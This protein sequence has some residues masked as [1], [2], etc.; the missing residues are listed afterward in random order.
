LAAAIATAG[1][2]PYVAAGYLSPDALHDAIVRTRELTPAPLGVNLFLVSPSTADA[3]A[4]DDY[5]QLL[6]PEA[7]NFGV[8]LGPPRWD[9]DAF[10]EK[11]D[12]IIA[13][14]VHTVSTTF[15]SPHEDVID[16]LHA[17]GIQ[18]AVTVTSPEEATTA[19]NAGADSLIVQGTEAGGHQ[20]TFDST[21]P[22]HTSLRDALAA[23][24]DVTTLPLI[25]TG[26][27]MTGEDAAAALR[28]GAAAVQVGTALL[29]T[30]EAGTS[31]PHRNAI[32]TGRYP[33]TMITRA[34][35]GRW[36]RGLANRF[37]TEHQDAPDGYPQINHLTRPLRAAATKAGDADVPNLWVGTGWRA[38][39]AEPAAAVVRRI[40]TEGGA[41]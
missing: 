26:G 30:P 25:A 4:I 19:L 13:A 34:F 21:T 22:N 39:V 36:A 40:A 31:T 11:I 10:D 9:D 23:V 37:A 16:R 27:I 15:G 29:L 20:G 3:A 32:A 12:R 17:A 7:R 1:G 2:F 6:E 33:D 24:P 8:Q 14:Q 5:A 35:T 38:A 28:A 18:V 41:R